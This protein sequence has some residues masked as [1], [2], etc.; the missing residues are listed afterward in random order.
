MTSIPDL[1][2]TVAAMQEAGYEIACHGWRWIS[3]QHMD[4]ATERAA[5]AAA[6]S[7]SALASLDPTSRA[8]ASALSSTSDRIKGGVRAGSKAC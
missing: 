7:R 6:S 2:P 3:Y 8:S 1:D 4:E 5:I